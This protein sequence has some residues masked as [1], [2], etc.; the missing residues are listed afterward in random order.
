MSLSKMTNEGI[1]NFFHHISICTIIYEEIFNTRGIS[2]VTCQIR[3][4]QSKRTSNMD[5]CNSIQR[6][7][8]QTAQLPLKK[9][10]NKI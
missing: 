2:Y 8:G 7:Y 5:Y 3:E 9:F 6:H 10:N 1:I 4:K